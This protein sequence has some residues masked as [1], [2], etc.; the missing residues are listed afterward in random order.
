MIYSHSNCASHVGNALI[1]HG[2]HVAEEWWLNKAATTI[3]MFFRRKHRVMRRL[4]QTQTAIRNR[5]SRRVL[6][7]VINTPNPRR[8]GRRRKRKRGPGRPRSKITSHEVVV[9][10]LITVTIHATYIF[11][12]TWRCMFWKYTGP[13]S[14]HYS[15]R[16]L[17]QEWQP[18]WRSASKT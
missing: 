13:K 15:L 12:H 7:N 18:R 6:V 17:Q 10:T 2:V 8:R 11:I 3:T 4:R 1:E 16:K 9:S 14:T 5:T